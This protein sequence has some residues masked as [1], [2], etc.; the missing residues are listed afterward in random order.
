MGF[1]TKHVMKN[2]AQINDVWRENPEIMIETT[3][4]SKFEADVESIKATGEIIKNKIH[5]L[6]GLQLDYYNKVGNLKP[7]ITRFRSYICYKFGKDSIQY[8]QSG[9]KRSSQRKSPKRK[10]SS[11]TP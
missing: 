6:K 4:F 8:E 2:A 7:I 3:S 11:T 1:S 10:A 5:E 9:C